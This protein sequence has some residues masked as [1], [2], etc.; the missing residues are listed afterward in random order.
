MRDLYEDE[1]F[2][3][4]ACRSQDVQAV[5]FY[6]CVFQGCQLN[7]SSLKRSRFTGCLF[8][9]CD[10]SMVDVTDAVFQ[11]TRFERTAL[12]GVNWSLID[13]SDLQGVGLDFDACTLNYA[14]FLGLDL[15]KGRMTD[16]SAREVYL[17]EVNFS[18]ADLSGTDFAGSTFM[19]C[20]LS[21]ADLR[22]AKNY[23][24]NVVSNKVTGVKVSLGEALGLLAGL[25][26]TFE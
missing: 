22:G 15:S 7:D 14:T 1:T 25:D 18:E 9:D 5:A 11:D 12:V 21:G 13:T 3:N 10:L 19:K 6:D 17:A 2:T 24:I 26:I 23:A 20:D 4:L 16:C 8:A